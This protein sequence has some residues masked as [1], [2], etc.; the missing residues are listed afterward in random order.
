MTKE[1]FHTPK[2]SIPES[3]KLYE[4]A[5]EKWNA[6]FFDDEGK[7]IRQGS[8][9]LSIMHKEVFIALCVIMN[10]RLKR[11]NLSK[12]HKYDVL[13]ESH[14]YIRN[15]FMF[16]VSTLDIQNVITQNQTEK[17]EIGRETI[18]RAMYRF[19]KDSEFIL[20]MSWRRGN[21]RYDLIIDPKL[22]HFQELHPS[23]EKACKSTFNNSKITNSLNYTIYNT[24]IN[25][26]K[27]NHTDFIED[28][29]SQANFN[30]TT[31]KNKNKKEQGKSITDRPFIDN[32]SLKNK[33]ETREN[34]VIEMTDKIK[35]FGD[36]RSSGEISKTIRQI[37]PEP[38]KTQR[39]NTDKFKKINDKFLQIKQ[40]IIQDF[41]ILMLNILWNPETIEIYS[42]YNLESP[43]Y[44]YTQQAIDELTY[45]SFYFGD[46]KTIE[47]FKRRK[48]LLSN[49][50][51]RMK[52]GWINKRKTFNT[53]YLAPNRFLNGSYD[54][55]K[56]ENAVIYHIEKEKHK[57]F[58]RRIKTEKKI[59][60]KQYDGLMNKFINHIQTG[61][62]ANS[63]AAQK[64]FILYGKKDESIGA[65]PRKE[66]TKKEIYKGLQYYFT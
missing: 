11:R 42:P 19:K 50:L 44:I 48:L 52:K 37:I 29:N 28:K 36:K 12:K 17:K 4:A 58:K 66:Y 1:K 25:N 56:F 13:T 24:N 15:P 51:E 45:N 3:R 7:F 2:V 62:N 21:S 34:T 23:D 5:A 6:Q 43:L 30:T 9:K 41:Y 59:T 57:K 46:C 27:S 20:R 60:Q 32:R 61:N 63:I 33:V 8:K 65:K 38:K 35:T 16:S 47:E 53:D 18:K 64:Y 31:T 26:N 22:L 39:F 54:H 14:N 10:A 49:A 40:S 55:M